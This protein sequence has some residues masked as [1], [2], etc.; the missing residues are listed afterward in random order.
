MSRIVPHDSRSSRI[1]LR[2]IMGPSGAA[3][4]STLQKPGHSVPHYDVHFR[5]GRHRISCQPL[6]S[7]TMGARWSMHAAAN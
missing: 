5:P 7:I 1:P 4:R 2:E 3:F 6:L